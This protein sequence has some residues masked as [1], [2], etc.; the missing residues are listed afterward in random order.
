MECQCLLSLQDLAP[1]CPEP[2]TH[3]TSGHSQSELTSPPLRPWPLAGLAMDLGVRG[4]PS[5]SCNRP[6]G[7]QSRNSQAAPTP[8][9]FK[10]SP[11]P[12][13]LDNYMDKTSTPPP[14][15]NS[16]LALP[17]LYCVTFCHSLLYACN[18]LQ[19]IFPISWRKVSPRC[20]P[21][22][23]LG[24]ES[25]RGCNKETRNTQEGNREHA[26]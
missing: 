6:L 4:S 16:G 19:L 8:A 22:C 18:G 13:P 5:P 17:V 14:P 15:R 26:S 1:R 25:R 24:Q 21:S 20:P 3:R 10:L 2:E 11:S 23:L 9:G 12:V 7:L